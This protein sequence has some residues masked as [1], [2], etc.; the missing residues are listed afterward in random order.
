MLLGARRPAPGPDNGCRMRTDIR[1][2]RLEGVLVVDVGAF[3]DE[4]GFF[5]ESWHRRTFA[6]AGLDVD[7]VQDNHSRSARGVLRGLHYQDLSAPM[8]KL[9]RCTLGRVYDVAVD[10][11]AGSPTY[12][13]WEAFELSDENLRQVWIP[14]GFGHG[15]AT[16]SD[17]ADVQ[18]KCSGY[19]TPAAEGAVAWNDPDL[20]VDWPVDS[21]TV[22]ERDRG[23][24][25]FAEYR[26]RPAF[27]YPVGP[28]P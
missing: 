28:A 8:G 22:S 18:Y 9:V 7:F 5:L 23:A 24:P 6:E 2:A 19:Y 10:L 26:S 21:P 1:P 17:L 13:E 3:R 11:R 27:T 25:S 20:A 16:L 4:R 15:F 14:A 12:G